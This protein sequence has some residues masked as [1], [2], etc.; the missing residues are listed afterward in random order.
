MND[1]EK[2]SIALIRHRNQLY[3]FEEDKDFF[4]RIKPLF[5]KIQSP[6]QRP[7]AYAFENGV[8]LVLEHFEIDSTGI[9]EHRGSEERLKNAETEKELDRQIKSFGIGMVTEEVIRSGECYVDNIINSFNRH[10]KKIDEYVKNVIGLIKEDIKEIIVGFVIEDSTKLGFWWGSDENGDS[11]IDIMQ[12]KE[13]LDLF[14]KTPNLDFVLFTTTTYE[15]NGYQKFLSKKTISEARKDEK[16]VSKIPAMQHFTT[17][18]AFNVS[19][20]NQRNIKK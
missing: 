5:L 7:D 6:P 20:K 2:I 13:F 11:Q 14:E 9:K 12:S 18:Y 15:N 17:T 10:A 4:Q 8:L 1:F 19:L 16:M 3:G